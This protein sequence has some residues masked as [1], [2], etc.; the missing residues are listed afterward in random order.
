MWYKEVEDWGDWY[1]ELYEDFSC[2]NKEQLCKREGEFIREIVTLN[3]QIAGRTAKEWGEDSPDKKRASCKKYPENHREERLEYKK[4]YKEK[5]KEK[6]AAYRADYWLN[7]EVNNKD[8]I[9]R[10]QRENR[11]KRGDKDEVNLRRRENYA[12]IGD[13]DEINRKRREIR[14]M[15]QNV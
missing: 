10:K 9:N 12:K 15:K 7:V 8:E 14:T 13:K 2:D 11:E 4:E 5:R 3:K 1:I 6:I